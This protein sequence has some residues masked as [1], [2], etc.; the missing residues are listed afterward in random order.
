MSTKNIWLTGFFLS[1]YTGKNANTLR[2]NELSQKPKIVA[3]SI[4]NP[5]DKQ[6][7]K[8]IFQK[9]FSLEYST[10]DNLIS[11]IKTFAVGKNGEIYIGYDYGSK[12]SIFD[13]NGGH[14]QTVT[15]ED[16]F[17]P[18]ARSTR[19]CRRILPLDKTKVGL[20]YF[21]FVNDLVIYDWKSKK[22]D[23]IPLKDKNDRR[24]HPVVDVAMA[25]DR[26]Y[27]LAHPQRTLG[28]FSGFPE[29]IA[30]D[31]KGAKLNS[32]AA[33]PG[34]KFPNLSEQFALNYDQIV[35]SESNV[36]YASNP[37]G[38]RIYRF[39]LS[40]KRLGDL[41]Y[42]EDYVDQLDNDAPADPR[43]WQ[44]YFPKLMGAD[45]IS[46]IFCVR[47][48]GMDNIVAV[49][50]K[51]GSVYFDLF[52]ENGVHTALGKYT[53][54]DFEDGK[55]TNSGNLFYGYKW[56]EVDND[57]FLAYGNPEIVVYRLDL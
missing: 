6:T 28:Y 43:T 37:L 23:F 26:I 35:L 25:R 17:G 48:N 27:L 21:G 2:K 36:L 15:E 53:V 45:L 12:L 16:V 32:F 7:K 13:Q 19:V 3:A 10:K 5:T 51:G 52:D 44:K 40:G 4:A 20:L 42:P 57:Q 33:F 49:R 24:A 11:Q 22:F 38:D 39:D 31:F 54:K 47:R 9:R 46:E 14:I 18:G 30:L 41:V 29:I 34:L 50:Q 55:I 1:F 56:P 8:L